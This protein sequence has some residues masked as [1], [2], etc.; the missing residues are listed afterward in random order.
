MLSC[1][2][3]E[4]SK[5]LKKIAHGWLWSDFRKWFFRTLFLESNFQRH[6]DFKNIPV[7]F[8]PEY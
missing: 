6:P 3:C 7:A 5:K 8:K 2:Y 1:E 4:I